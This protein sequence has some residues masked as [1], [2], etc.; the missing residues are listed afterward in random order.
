MRGQPMPQFDLRNKDGKIDPLAPFKV[1]AV[2]CHPT[3]R[4]RRE[5][6]L[7]PIQKE[8]RQGTASTAAVSSEEFMAEVRRNSRRAAVAGGLTQTMI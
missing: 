6:V 2:M 8:T 5:Q 1:L 7:A 3:S 4:L